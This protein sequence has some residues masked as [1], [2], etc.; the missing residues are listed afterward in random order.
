M[1]KIKKVILDFFLCL[2]LRRDYNFEMLKIKKF[3]GACV[4]QLIK[5]PILVFSSGHI[6]WLVGLGPMF[7]SVLASLESAW[8]SLLSL[9]ALPHSTCSLSFKIHK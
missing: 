9:P 2:F 4:A 6:S 8:D 3:R 5:C 7:S 1:E